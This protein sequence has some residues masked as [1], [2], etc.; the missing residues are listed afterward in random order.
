VAAIFL[1]IRFNYLTK[2]LVHKQLKE[3]V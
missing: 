1:Y 3:Q 2:K